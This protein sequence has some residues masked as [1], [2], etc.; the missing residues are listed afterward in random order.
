RAHG[1]SQS[2][3]DH[4]RRPAARPDAGVPASASWAPAQVA[5][6]ACLGVLPAR[7]DLDAVA[8][9]RPRTPRRAPDPRDS[10]PSLC[11]VAGLDRSA[12]R[13]CAR[14]RVRRALAAPLLLGRDRVTPADRREIDERALRGLRLHPARPA[15]EPTARARAEHILGLLRV[16]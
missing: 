13:R 1:R 10:V 9:R 6:R 11:M 8:E 12:P 2:S 16:R 14:A 3:W 4:A 5:A 7:A 15:Y